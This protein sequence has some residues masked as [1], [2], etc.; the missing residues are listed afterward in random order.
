MSWPKRK[1]QSGS[2]QKLKHELRRRGKTRLLLPRRVSLQESRTAE[3]ARSLLYE[4][5]KIPVHHYL[6]RLNINVTAHELKASLYTRAM[7]Q[8]RLTSW[9]TVTFIL[10]LE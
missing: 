7:L 3:R 4:K 9:K 6:Q 2:R 8:R 10:L 5:L 1:K